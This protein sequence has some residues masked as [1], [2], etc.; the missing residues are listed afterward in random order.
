M[1]TSANK[2][3]IVHAFEEIAAGNGR[4]FVDMMSADIEWRIIGTTAWSKVYR[5]KGEVL[6]LL[7]AL[8]D[9]FVD[10]KNVILAQ[11]IHADGAFVIVEARGD[12][13]TT[14][15]KSYANEYCWVFRFAEGKVVEMVEYA[16]TQLMVE[17]LTPP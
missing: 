12:N 11:R 17:A 16:D 4:A 10:G 5:G 15:G 9:Q 13:R 3:I 6:A 14:S 7:R 8:R 1:S 2:A